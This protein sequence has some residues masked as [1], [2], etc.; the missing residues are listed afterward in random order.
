[1]S[2]EWEWLS[3]YGGEDKL[4]KIKLFQS[5]ELEE[6]ELKINKFLEEKTNVRIFD[7][8][9]NSSLIV[10]ETMDSQHSGR[11]G[12]NHVAMIVYEV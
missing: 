10:N 2:M 5:S 3:G 4:R 12:F 9:L 7:I 6:L 8:K 11:S 1:M